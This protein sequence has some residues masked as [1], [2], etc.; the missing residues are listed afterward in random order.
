MSASAVGVG[1][2]ASG[3]SEH[4]DISWVADY[5]GIPWTDAGAT[6]LGVNCWGL[7]ALVYR[8]RAGIELPLYEDWRWESDLKPLS[9]EAQALRRSISQKITTEAEAW[10]AVRINERRTLDV[11]LIRQMGWPCHVGLFVAP[12][13]VLHAEAKLDTACERL[14]AE[15]FVKLNRIIGCYRHARLC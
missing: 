4:E 3:A 9:V 14:D 1:W 2:P 5:I 8:E 13:R 6:Y 11:L 15:R 7:V 12:N 10:T